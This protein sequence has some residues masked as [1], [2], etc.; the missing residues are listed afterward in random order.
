MTEITEAFLRALPKTDLHMHLE[1][2]LEPETMFMLAQRNGLTLRW[3]S[4][5]AL[6]AA[7]AFRDLPDFLALYFEACAVLCSERDFHD[8]TAAYLRRARQ[9]GVAHAEIFFGPQSFTERGIPVAAMMDGILGAIAEAE[10]A[11]FSAGLLVS[12]HRH[13]SEE[14]A[15]EVLRAVEPWSDRILGIGMGGAEIGNPPMKFARFFRAAQDAGFPTMVHAGE[16]GPAAYVRDALDL[17]VQRI[18]HGV[19]AAADPALVADLAARG[20]PLTVCPLSNLRLNVVPSLAAHPLASLL[21][22]GV[23]VTVNSDDP[24]YFGGWVTENLLACA[25]AMDLSRA[26]IVQL[27]RNGFDAAFVPEPRRAALHAQL[28]ASLAG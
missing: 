22:A 10:D 13:R 2:S 4:P 15:F 8:A 19:A 5:E 11:A 26:E 16:E 18:D 28:E 1:G 12:V 20:V 3:P 27:L 23:R 14:A 9:D 17:D 6:R 7:Y 25:Q 21:R 24:P